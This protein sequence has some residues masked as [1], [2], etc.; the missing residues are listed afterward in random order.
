MEHKIYRGRSGGRRWT[1]NVCLSR[2]TRRH[3][4]IGLVVVI[5]LMV[6][7]TGSQHFSSIGVTSNQQSDKK[8]NKSA[9][10]EGND[11][12]KDKE[13]EKGPEFCT[14]WP[15]DEDGKYHREM[16]TSP[17]RQLHLD[18]FAPE[19]GWK[20]P[21]GLS[22]VGMIFYG[23]KRNVD[24]L[25]CYLRQ[26]LA[27]NGGYLDEVWFMVHTENK[28]DVDWLRDLVKDEPDYKYIDLGNRTT[29][30]YGYMW[31]YPVEDDTIYVKIDDDV[32][33]C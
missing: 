17:E 21:E 23:R 15:V 30:Y 11:K 22:V 18:S 24:I 31:E 32:V 9:G 27:S 29:D 5:A 10:A 33:S 14:T 20:K 2:L 4:F 16:E 1:L 7:S 26:N 13:K 12:N 3:F 25:D 28:Q 19:G 6:F 8:P